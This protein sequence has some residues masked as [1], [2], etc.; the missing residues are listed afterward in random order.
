M[1]LECGH[2]LPLS[3]FLFIAAFPFSFAPSLLSRHTGQNRQR[4]GKA[5]IN[6]RT[7]KTDTP[8]NTLR[9]LIGRRER[10]SPT[11]PTSPTGP[12]GTQSPGLAPSTPSGSRTPCNAAFCIQR[13]TAKAR[14]WVPGMEGI[15]CFSVYT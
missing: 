6:S 2:S 1:T 7:P 3:P 4:G 14:T 13:L 11:P 8:T 10:N 9:D 12:A 5:A 15:F